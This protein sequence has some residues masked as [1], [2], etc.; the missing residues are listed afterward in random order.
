MA[1]LFFEYA[2]IPYLYDT[3]RSKLYQI[4]HNRLL[5][6][7]DPEILKNVR[8]NSAEICRERAYIL[9]QNHNKFTLDQ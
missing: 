5:D 6:I 7:R 4:E 3:K 9:A 2:K 1:E 8:F